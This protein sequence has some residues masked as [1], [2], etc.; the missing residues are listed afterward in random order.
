[1]IYSCNGQLWH[2]GVEY[3]Y[4]IHLLDRDTR[5]KRGHPV[6]V[7]SST[8]VLHPSR[9]YTNYYVRPNDSL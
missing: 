5:V 1:M 4:G 3:P 9:V 8:L 2:H 6:I 7:H